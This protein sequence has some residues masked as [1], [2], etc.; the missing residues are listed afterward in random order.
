M[1]SNAMRA[2]QYSR[3]G[4]PGVIEIV[5]VAV[6]RPRA[7]EVLV[8]V[9]AT[10]VNG[11]EAAIRAGR[12]RVVSGRRFPRGLGI[13]F[14]GEVVAVGASV[15]E[16]AVG[17]RV[18]G[19]LDNRTVVRGGL[20]TGAAAQYV[21]VAASLTAPAPG[22]LDAAA[23]VSLLA[24]NAALFAL[25]DRAELHRG[26]RLLVRGG[27]GG[28][29]FAAVQVG[30]AMGAEVT[31][32][33]SAPNIP[34]AIEIGARVALD[35]RSTGP[36]DLGLF[37]VVF[38]T[39]GSDMEAYR[40]RLAP[41]GR[42]ITISANPPLRGFL[43]VLASSLR[44]SR[45]IQYLLAEPTRELLDDY[46]ELVVSGEVAPLIASEHGLDELA[47]AHRAFERG[48]RPGKHVVRI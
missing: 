24:G 1:N 33:V 47:D 19:M 40:N 34:T 38:D 16:P 46:A 32:L 7:E 20:A 3:F 15:T 25:R 4:D 27:T 6:P 42:M 26:E 39:V 5:E 9:H 11:G 2:A 41:G 12:L 48:G 37:D 35:H 22:G 8:R 31:T 14:V 45:R 29:G 36:G 23:A 44:R 21:A 43:T 10:S 30:R 28:V 17:A 13:D 18:W